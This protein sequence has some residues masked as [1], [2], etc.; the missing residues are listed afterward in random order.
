[1]NT[2]DA[3]SDLFRIPQNRYP[4]GTNSERAIA[5][6]AAIL[7][8]DAENWPLLDRDGKKVVTAAGYAT[9]HM[10]IHIDGDEMLAE[11]SY[12]KEFAGKFLQDASER[13]FLISKGEWGPLRSFGSSGGTPPN[14]DSGIKIIIQRKN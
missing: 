4:K 7:F 1:M 6:N 14:S 10:C 3:T 8:P 11:L 9:W 13:I 2:D 12:F 5:V